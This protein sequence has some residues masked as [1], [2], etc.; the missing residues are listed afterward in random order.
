MKINIIGTGYVGLT[1]CAFLARHDNKIICSDNNREK[2]SQLKNN[3]F[4]CSEPY[5]LDIIQNKENIS[6]DT[7]YHVNQDIYLVC[8]GTPNDGKIPDLSQIKSIISELKS[9]V[10]SQS[11]I[12]L[13]STILPGTTKLFKELLGLD[14]PVYFIPEF[15]SEGNAFQ[16]YVNAEKIIIGALESEKSNI[17]LTQFLSFHTCPEIHFSDYE[18]AELTKYA[19]NIMLASRLATMNQIA[20]VADKVGANMKDIEYFVGLDSRIGSKYLKS[21]LGFGGSCLEKDLV[22]LDYISHQDTTIFENIIINNRYQAQ[23]FSEKIISTLN[24]IP[25]IKTVVLSGLTFKNNTDD[26]RHS[27]AVYVLQYLMKAGY[28]IKLHDII[29]HKKGILNNFIPEF[30]RLTSIQ[31][32]REINHFSSVTLKEYLLTASQPIFD[33][34]EIVEDIHYSLRDAHALVLCQKHEPFELNYPYV[35]EHM[36][37]PNIFDPNKYLDKEKAIKLGISYTSIGY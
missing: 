30:E 18:T 3:T 2:I 24:K 28:K 33:Q 15:L 35:K 1:C 12:I 13:K 19:N 32:K 27:C 29:L 14:N 21:G 8:V 20:L 9:C 5:I 34:I 11:I 4:D 10:S 37:E 22:A 31:L 17:L 16:D 25:G 36:A 6:F 23:Y 7:Q 26:C